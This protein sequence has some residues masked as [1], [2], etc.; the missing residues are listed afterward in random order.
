M[1]ATYDL[2]SIL[3]ACADLPVERFAPGAVLIAEGPAIGHLYVLISGTV[4]VLRGDTQISE[5][6]EPGAIFGE[7]SALLGQDHSATVK[8]TTATEAYR[9]DDAAAALRGNPDL[10][11]HVA[12]ILAR[13]LIG[14]TNY[15]ADL[16]EQFAHRSDHLGMVDTVLDALVQRQRSTAATG[17]TLTTDPRL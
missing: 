6:A 14:A 13:R 16:K 2:A 11:Y 15:L 3:P 1:S 17:S 10:L 7:M 8:A 9:L 4:E 12:T 5:I